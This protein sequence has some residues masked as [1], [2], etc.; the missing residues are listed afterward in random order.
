MSLGRGCSIHG[1][2]LRAWRQREGLSTGLCGG[3]LEA[4]P[5][6]Y[7]TRSCAYWPS[8]GRLGA[9]RPFLLAVLAGRCCP[10][11]CA[12]SCPDCP[13][14][15][16][17]CAQGHSHGAGHALGVA[18]LEASLAAHHEVPATQTCSLPIA[19][20]IIAVRRPLVLQDDDASC[21]VSLASRG[22]RRS[23]LDRLN[24]IVMVCASPGSIIA[25]VPSAV[26]MSTVLQNALVACVR[27]ASSIPQ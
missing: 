7:R 26:R 15:P 24:T 19:A 22:G 27:A 11:V 6:C 3:D 21:C 4:G 25:Q 12:R 18:P 14:C 10:R 20:S 8:T 16:D 5:Q 23:G 13:D 17:C 2:C 9:G 1:A